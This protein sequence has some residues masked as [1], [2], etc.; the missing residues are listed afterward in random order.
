[1]NILFLNHAKSQ[2]GVYN[3]GTRLYDI[4]KKSNKLE[5][6]YLEV[7]SLEEYNQIN[8]DNF[9]FIVYNYHVCTMEWL[10]PRTITKKS[11]NIGILHECYPQLF[12][13]CI[14]T[15]SDI[16]R[17]IFESI[18]SK[19][20]SNDT[21]VV[22]FLEY[23]LNTNIPII[24]SFGFG[25]TNKGFDKIVNYVNQQ[26]DKAIIKIIMPF[27]DYG[28]KTGEKSRYVSSL[29]SMTNKK[30]GIEILIIHDFLHDNDIL[31]FLSKNNVNVFLYDKMEGRG[32]SSTI[33]F[34]MSVHTP[35]CISDSYMFRHIYN[36][37]ICLYKNSFSECIT[38]SIEYMKQFREIYSH[39]NSIKFIE[40]FILSINLK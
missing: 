18:T 3:Y 39:K 1:M 23:G 2:C 28:D 22:N 11:I 33:D 32:I 30:P 27:A 34:A 38:N 5:F 16:P 36:D 40:D 9:K 17:P 15:Q 10:K 35:L 31:Y 8:F 26:F 7:N 37:S 13:Y 6:I 29:C 19:I 24:G 4:W 14:N 25:F 21:S 20:Q 12:H